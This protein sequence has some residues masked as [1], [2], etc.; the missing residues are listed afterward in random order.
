MEYIAYRDHAFDWAEAA[1]TVY[2]GV[3]DA[4]TGV[5][6]ATDANIASYAGEA[7][8]GEWISS[9]DV[10]AEGA[11]PTTGAQVVYRLAEPL[12]YRLTPEEIRTAMGNNGFAANTG[13]VTVVYSADTKLYIDKRITALIN[14]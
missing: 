8:P 10:Y 11:T 4:T 6:T 9:M 12:V 5:L 2:G 14:T 7:L 3:L 13:D 1:G